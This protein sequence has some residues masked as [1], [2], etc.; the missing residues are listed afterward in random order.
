MLDVRLAEQPLLDA[1]LVLSN[2]QRHVKLCQKRS[3]KVVSP[4]D[5]DL[6]TDST[7]G[8][9]S[10][11]SSFIP[12]PDTTAA[13]D[14]SARRPNEVP[15]RP[16]PASHGSSGNSLVGVGPAALERSVSVGS[17]GVEGSEGVGIKVEPSGMVVASSSAYSYSE[18]G[19]YD[20]PS[21]SSGFGG[22][23]ESG[24]TFESV[25]PS[26]EHPQTIYEEPAS[27]YSSSGPSFDAAGSG[28]DAA[29]S[30][31]YDT[32]RANTGYEPSTSGAYGHAGPG[33]DPIG[34]SQ[35]GPSESAYGQSGPT[36]EQAGSSGAEYSQQSAAEYG[37]SYS[38][39][40]HP[41][42]THIRPHPSPSHVQVQPLPSPT[43]V[44]ASSPSV[45][46][47]PAMLGTPTMHT[48]P[49]M[50]PDSNYLSPTTSTPG[51]SVSRS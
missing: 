46:G 1:G 39:Y 16:K 5:D 25:R 32:V 31:S 36:Y 23:D 2:C 6:N 43:H 21:G 27:E 20:Q 9:S 7:G 48:V 30:T 44:H 24:S 42:P 47:A 18:S 4:G 29:R 11:S 28:F 41:S 45:Y 49:S 51:M 37:P 50:R 3:T 10:A 17:S 34:S 22:Y 35:Y 26:F 13:T 12:Y 38:D 14:E 15:I 19:G 8:P 40:S 33:Y